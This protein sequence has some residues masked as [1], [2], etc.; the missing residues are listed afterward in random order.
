LIFVYIC[1]NMGISDTTKALVRERHPQATT[2][3]ASPPPGAFWNRML[4]WREG[5]RIGR[6]NWSFLGG[7]DRDKP[8][9]GDNMAD[10]VVRRALARDP[11]LRKFLNWSILPVSKVTRAG[12]TAK[13]LIADARYGLP[14]ENSARLY[15]ETTVDLCA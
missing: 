4:V 9:I 12:C 3:F 2:I 13:V 5:D 15:R 1:L 6:A 14:G 8:A 10:P 7:L 11:R